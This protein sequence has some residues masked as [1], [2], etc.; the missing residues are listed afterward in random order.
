MGLHRGLAIIIGLAGVMIVLR[1]GQEPLSLGHLS[2]LA[3]ALLGAMTSVIV[4][5]IG[6]DDR[7]VVLMLYPM[8]A[9]FAVMALLPYCASWLSSWRSSAA[10]ASGRP[11]KLLRAS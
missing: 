1:P 11:V 5:K 6:H 2:A 8:V 7:S 9:I 10:R 4:R 3:A